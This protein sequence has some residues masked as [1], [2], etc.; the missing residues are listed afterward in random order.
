MAKFRESKLRER[1][2]EL[3]F[4]FEMRELLSSS[5]RLKDLLRGELYKVLE[6]FVLDAGRICLAHDDGQHLP[7]AAHQE[8][9]SK[10]L[11]KIGITGRFRSYGKAYER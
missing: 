3:S 6:Y 2:K 1:N 9:D 8:I 7:P 4:L 10:G 11:E 5:R